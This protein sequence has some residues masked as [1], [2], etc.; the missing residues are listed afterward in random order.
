MKD[1]QSIHAREKSDSITHLVKIVAREVVK[2]ELAKLEKRNRQDLRPI[3][4]KLC[5]ELISVL[6]RVGKKWEQAEDD[7]LVVELNVALNKIAQNH[8]RTEK[9]IL[10]RIN[11]KELLVD[12][13]KR[14]PRYIN[15]H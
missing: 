5:G 2:E 6:D 7:L 15:R 4:E 12:E 9:A 3:T 11:D 13:F 14:Y 10:C 8:G 1:F